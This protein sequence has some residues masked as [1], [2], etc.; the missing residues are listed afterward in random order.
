M[1]PTPSI[2]PSSSPTPSPSLYLSA[3]ASP[4]F[5]LAA[6]EKPVVVTFAFIVTG[7]SLTST[8]ISNPVVVKTVKSQWASL[9]GVSSASVYV[10]FVTD[11]ATGVVSGPYVPNDSINQGR[12]RRLS[13]SVKDNGSGPLGQSVVKAR[14]AIRRVLATT[15]ISVG[16]AVNLASSSGNPSDDVALVK[17]HS[18]SNIANNAALASSVF[19]PIANSVAGVSGTSASSFNFKVDEDSVSVSNLQRD[20]VVKKVEPLDP[21]IQAA[22]V[23]FVTIGS[24]MLYIYVLKPLRI[25]FH[26]F[27]SKHISCLKTLT[28]DEVKVSPVDVSQGLAASVSPSEA[29]WVMAPIDQVRLASERGNAGAQAQLGRRM[30]YGVGG[31]EKDPRSAAEWLE[32]AA[33]SKQRE[34][35]RVIQS[36]SETVQVSP[37]TLYSSKHSDSGASFNS[38]FGTATIDL[39]NRADNA[40]KVFE[41]ADSEIEAHQMN[42]RSDSS[43]TMSEGVDENAVSTFSEAQVDTDGDKKVV[44]RV[45]VRAENGKQEEANDMSNFSMEFTPPDEVPTGAFRK[46]KSVASDAELRQRADLAQRRLRESGLGGNS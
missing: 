24:M 36:E 9:L 37:K 5:A 13:D 46:P 21:G 39:E 1:T 6:I 3:S 12:R 30:L 33:R 7:S 23:I 35:R 10:Q 8:T 22:I 18:I 20:I 19:G 44:Q 25:R 45:F 15:G 42:S 28:I 43:A 26:S 32:R 34:K 38:T 14:F 4:G 2:T 31:C 17:A 27:L 29:E 41:A 11:L 40:I 16:M